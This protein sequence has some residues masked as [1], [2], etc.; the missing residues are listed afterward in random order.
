PS[1]PIA[2]A[3]SAGFAEDGRRSSA[4]RL[5]L[6]RKVDRVLRRREDTPDHRLEELEGRRVVARIEAV[7]I[8]AAAEVRAGLPVRMIA[9]AVAHVPIEPQVMEEV[10]ALEDAVVLDDP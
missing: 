10:V 6:V 3:T 9:V 5:P 2:A 8:V 1:R 7:L 4:I